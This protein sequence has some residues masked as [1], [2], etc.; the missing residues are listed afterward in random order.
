MEFVY[1]ASP[2]EHSRE[3]SAALDENLREALSGQ[4]RGR[5]LQIQFPRARRHLE[6]SRSE[7]LQNPAATL[8][9]PRTTQ[10]PGSIGALAIE[11]RTRRHAQLGID[12]NPNRPVNDATTAASS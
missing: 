6:Q 12:Q 5:A 8:P 10:D 4:P 7:V 9:N 2:Q 11:F 1:Q 3:A